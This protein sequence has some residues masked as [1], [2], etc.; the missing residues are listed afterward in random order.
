MNQATTRRYLIIGVVS[1][2]VSLFLLPIAGLGSI[3]SGYKVKN[4]LPALYSALLAGVGGFAV[5]N[6]LIYL[7]AL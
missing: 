1:A 5:V 7:I 2:L 3:Y 6:W 4:H